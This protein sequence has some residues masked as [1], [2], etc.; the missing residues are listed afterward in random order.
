MF[1]VSCADSNR[2][3]T[4]GRQ[5]SVV[6]KQG[7]SGGQKYYQLGPQF[8]ENLDTMVGQEIMLL[9]GRKEDL[10][11]ELNQEVLVNLRYFLNDARGFMIRSLSRGQKYIPMM[12]AILRQKGLPEDLVY[13]ALIESGFRTEAV[14]SASAVGPWQFIAPTGRR[15]GLV[16]DQWV[17]ERMDPVKSTYA[18]A[19]YLTTLHEL[20]NSW[21]LAIAAYN[22]GEGKILK[23]MKDPDTNNYWDM[24]K[25]EGFL[26]NETKRYVPSFLAAAI[27]SK[28]PRA[29]GLEI[30]PSPPDAWEDVVVPESIDLGLAAELANSDLSR[31]K[32]LNP[33]LKKQTTPPN[34]TNFV[35]RVPEGS[36][37]NF[38]RM[39][40][41]LPAAKRGGS[42]I[43]YTARRGE[44]IDQVATRHNLTPAV[45]RQY[46]NLPAG[47]K[48]ASGQKLVLPTSMP[49]ESYSDTV[50]A[51]AKQQ[52]SRRPVAYTPPVIIEQDFPPSESTPTGVRGP[53]STEPQRPVAVASSRSRRNPVINSISHRVRSGDTILGIAKLYGVKAEQV[54]SDN[55]LASNAIREGQV[56]NIRSNL[57]LTADTSSGTSRR[58]WV[59]VS[60]G[61]P[62]THKVQ[63]GETISTIAANYR[64]S[65]RQLM[66][67]NNLSDE[68]VIRV[69]QELKIGTVPA[70]S[71]ALTG[72]A[73]Y[74]VVSGDTISTIADRYGLSSEELRGINN[75]SS[76][77][78]QIGQVLKV[79]AISK[80][81]T[82]SGRSGD[83][84]S[85]V[86]QSLGMSQDNLKKV[87]DISSDLLKVGQKLKV[88]A[89]GTIE[90][91][92]LVASGDTV[93][94]I[95]ERH[96]MKTVE[97]KELN[98]LSD[99]NIRVGQKLKV[100]VGSQTIRKDGTSER[101]ATTD[102]S[103]VSTAPAATGPAPA[104]TTSSALTST[105]GAQTTYIVQS[106]DT[107]SQIAENFGLK[108]DELRRLNNLSNDNIRSGQKLLISGQPQSTVAKGTAAESSAANTSAQRTTAPSSTAAIKAENTYVVQTGDT[109]GQIA[110]DFGLRLAEL[111]AINQLQ[112]DNIRVGQRLF[113]PGPKTGQSQTA[114]AQRTSAATTTSSSSSSAGG[115]AVYVVQ[116]GDTVSQIA[117]NF[118]FSSAELRE[119]NNLSGDKIRVGQKLKVGSSRAASNQTNRTQTTQAASAQRPAASTSTASTDVYVV[120]SGDTVSQIAENFGLR[121]VELRELNNLSG[122]NIRVGQK[123]KVKAGK[124]TAS[125]TRASATQSTGSGGNYKVVP[126]DTMYSIATKHKLTVA[127]LKALNNKQNE[128]VRPGEVLKTK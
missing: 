105:I 8:E 70:A 27:I 30:E 43:T 50:V 106:G 29:Y 71:R 54:K 101:L 121:S 90:Q 78:L 75:L 11:L 46:N 17:D 97:L 117:E 48:L 52:Q 119:L 41:Q 87:S 38:Y 24:A 89:G 118:G 47:T 1:I 80:S 125:V 42:L 66:D 67:L 128:I 112:D 95:A 88:A 9:S 98:N 103:L 110:E 91:E 55:K 5:A 34:E 21:P 49:P 39:Y 6:A 116:T 22:S 59:Q 124:P 73:E 111:K 114:S 25:R 85:G 84:V 126:G 83:P 76:N 65:Q 109:I 86:A 72:S 79:P 68:A 60:E 123:L 58:S 113:V 122:D 51:S 12:K 92:Y 107:V 18:A 115:G 127:Q 37:A 93:S 23:G 13:L 19:D 31:I 32:E 96:N 120:Q 69:G 61:I 57:P 94:T 81:T 36:R 3:S 20:F 104:S 35:L 33:H 74:K 26:A 82:G 10:P 2:T 7:R 14:S 45:V 44:S 16:I 102:S 108:S 56:L 4:I 15:Y 100:L 99:N 53:S 40:A 64:V 63:T 28:D 62:A 77:T